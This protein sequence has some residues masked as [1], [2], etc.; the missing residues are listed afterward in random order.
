MVRAGIE[1]LVDVRLTV[2][3]D[4]FVQEA[5]IIK[6]SQREFE[7][8]TLIAVRHWKFLEVKEPAQ[9]ETLGATVDCRIKFGFDE[10]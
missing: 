10:S 9:A 2:G 4:G 1:G 7:E 8:P 6:S 3:K 5:H